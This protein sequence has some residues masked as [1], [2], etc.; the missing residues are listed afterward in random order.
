MHESGTLKFWELG[1][2]KTKMGLV[3]TKI[4]IFHLYPQ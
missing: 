4:S 1:V 3:S 2:R